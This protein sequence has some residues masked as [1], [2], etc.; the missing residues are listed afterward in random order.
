ME[1]ILNII[2]KILPENIAY[3]HCDIPCGIY[4]PNSAQLGA[5]TI[6][7]MTTLLEEV[8]KVS[9]AQMS[10][11]VARLTQVKEEHGELVENALG[12]LENDYFKKDHFSAFPELKS[13]IEKAVAL[14]VTTRQ[15]IDKKSAEEL[16]ETVL[17]ISEIFY[18][19]KNL[20]PIRV[21]SVYPTEKEIVAYK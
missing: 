8:E 21:K 18:K 9:E 12:T 4:D 10:H 1:K 15:K 16:L 7:R 11:D 13:L 6:L 20:T 5:H 14:S 19:T 2:L 17:Q 3:A